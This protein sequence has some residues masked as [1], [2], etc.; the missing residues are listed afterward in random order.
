MDLSPAFGLWLGFT[1]SL[2]ALSLIIRDNLL[3]RLAQ[4]IL[5]G[6]ASGYLMVLV[7]QDIL[8]PKL[9]E[10][11]TA[12]G[13]AALDLLIPLILGLCLVVAGVDG[14]IRQGINA[15]RRRVDRETSV[16]S[17]ISSGPK[18]LFSSIYDFV[19]GIGRV[20]LVLI[21]GVGIANAV[22]GTIQ[23]T[24]IPQFW[25]ATRI[26]L[27]DGLITALVSDTADA[28]TMGALVA[29]FVTIG[30]ILHLYVVPRDA[31]Q[32]R[33]LTVEDDGLGDDGRNLSEGKA[34]P[35][36][37]KSGSATGISKVAES[38]TN[39]FLIQVWAAAGKRALW[40][41]A[42]VLF[43]RL[44]ASRLSLL[45]ARIEYFVE[46]LERTAIWRQLIRLIEPFFG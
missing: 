3:S 27:N 11:L 29:L 6:S 41:A 16:D 4:Y 9:L 32:G 25:Q 1:L 43:A 38:L 14:T 12:T 17:D 24:L 34:I 13:P 18:T 7:I 21:V 45:I 33:P 5:V 30:T 2:M 26:Q 37:R 19:V 22:T 20:A 36:A 39:N 10:P 15:G 42:G 31:S 8:R 46:I 35:T 28:S 40:F 23:G 44:A